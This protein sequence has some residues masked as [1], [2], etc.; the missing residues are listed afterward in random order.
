[1][2]VK[3]EKPNAIYNYSNSI[4]QKI[5]SAIPDA[6]NK[7]I[8]QTNLMNDLMNELTVLFANYLNKIQISDNSEISENLKNS[9]VD[10][11]VEK[12]ATSD[13][14]T[15]H[16]TEQNNTPQLNDK[17]TRST[18]I[19]IENDKLGLN[20][21]NKCSNSNSSNECFKILSQL[22][23]IEINSTAYILKLL[24]N[25]IINVNPDIRSPYFDLTPGT[26]L[27]NVWAN[28]E[29]NIDFINT[30]SY[31]G[32]ARLIMAFG[33]SS[34][35]KTYW[36]KNIIQMMNKATQHINEEFPK[37]FL[38]I[39]GGIAREQSVI[40][41]MIRDVAHI[42]GWAGVK[43]LVNPGIGSS[44]FNSSIIK[45]TLYN[46][47]IKKKTTSSLNPNQNTDNNQMNHPKIFSLYVPETL[48]GLQKN[49]PK[50]QITQY[51]NDEEWIG[52]NIWMCKKKCKF[53]KYA[54]LECR[55]TTEAGSSRQLVEGKQYSGNAW[56]ISRI[57]GILEAKRAPGGGINIHNAGKKDGVSIISKL[58][59]KRNKLC[60]WL[61]EVANSIY[62]KNDPN[63]IIRSN[64]ITVNK[65][66][67]G[68][69]QI[70]LHDLN[71]TFLYISEKESNNFKD[72]KLIEQNVL[73]GS[74]KTKKKSK[75]K[76]K[77][78]QKRQ[79]NTKKA[80]QNKKG[81]AK[82]K[83]QSKTARKTARKNK[84]N[85]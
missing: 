71:A 69:E 80:N 66:D 3:R 76:V 11:L 14:N 37:I 20:W 82:Q 79:N 30:D 61:D 41:Q 81:K 35:G 65:S 29:E 32:N 2:L 38:S 78:K 15:M 77:A 7:N 9:L 10:N 21:Y 6:P 75:Q 48:A 58:G 42:K 43:H 60:E 52:L 49:V 19:S 57:K 63:N 27:N 24:H 13:S 74:S 67:L 51:V 39:D 23:N 62:L 55:T 31:N 70:S 64:E 83:R 44:I 73:G 12:L 8:N 85:Y 54:K 72:E 22:I 47:L 50:K 1:M 59:T 36:T 18:G 26:E 56:H 40:Y 28:D 25:S 33:P 46:F 53:N 45:N 17:T 84:G 4:I 16:E 34:S 5:M 68:V